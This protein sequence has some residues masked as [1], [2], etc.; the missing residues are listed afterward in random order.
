[1]K[2]TW[3]TNKLSFAQSLR[4]AGDKEFVDMK[5]KHKTKGGKK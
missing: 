1:M 2:K 3:W 4:Q 5:N